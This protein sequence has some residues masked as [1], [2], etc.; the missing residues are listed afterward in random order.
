VV[1][2]LCLMVTPPRYIAE[3]VLRQDCID[4]TLTELFKKVADAEH[5]SLRPLEGRFAVRDPR[6]YDVHTRNSLEG[7]QELKSGLGGRLM[8]VRWEG[9]SEL[10]YATPLDR[11]VRVEFDFGRRMSRA[12]LIHGI[13]AEEL[14]VSEFYGVE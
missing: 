1:E 3:S 4:V 6:N 8:V 13:I 7:E 14:A 5:E 10:P 11:R 12:Y 9:A 2:L